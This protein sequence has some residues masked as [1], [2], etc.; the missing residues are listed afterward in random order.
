MRTVKYLAGFGLRTEIVDLVL[1]LVHVGVKMG[2]QQVRIGDVVYRFIK[3]DVLLIFG[4]HMRGKRRL[5]LRNIVQ[6]EELLGYVIHGTIGYA[7]CDVGPNG[8]ELRCTLSVAQNVFRRATTPTNAL[9]PNV[10]VN[11]SGALIVEV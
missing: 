10:W 8:L 5:L 2:L 1:S 6:R 3:R 9:V 11:A 7:F 4:S